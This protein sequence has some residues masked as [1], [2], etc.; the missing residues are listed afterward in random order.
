MRYL[1]NLLTIL[2]IMFAPLLFYL[3][4]EAHGYWDYIVLYYMFVFA[5]LTD[6][7]D[8]SLA[9]SRNQVTTFGKFVDPIADKLILA[10]T[11]I[12][13]Y[14]LSSRVPEFQ[15][16]T[17]PILLI[18]LGREVAITLLRYYSMW[19]GF[20]FSASRLAK[21]KTAFQMFFIGSVLVHM[22]H[23]RIMVE[24]PE[25]AFRWFDP[26]HMKMNEVVILVVVALSVISAVEYVAR[27]LPSLVRQPRA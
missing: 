9:R 4:Y 7:Y 17:L 25:L 1:P 5:G 12:P 14:L 2:R 3:I 6:I 16:V 26:F 22:A 20:V 8:G 27:N 13:F 21:F 23:R 15:P 10:C 19:T 24:R 18:L 11:L